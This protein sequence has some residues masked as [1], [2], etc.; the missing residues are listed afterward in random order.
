MTKTSKRAETIEV[1]KEKIRGSL[2]LLAIYIPEPCEGRRSEIFCAVVGGTKEEVLD[3][4]KDKPLG[5]MSL[6]LSVIDIRMIE[7]V[8]VKEFSIPVMTLDQL[9]EFFSSEKNWSLADYNL[10]V[11]KMNARLRSANSIYRGIYNGDL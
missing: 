9:V 1:C 4:I 2:R 8:Y 10:L 7:D 11:R 6:N 3:I 5:A